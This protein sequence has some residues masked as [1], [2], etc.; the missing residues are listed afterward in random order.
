[1]ATSYVAGYVAY[2]LTLDSS[3]T[4]AIVDS[5]IKAQSLKNILSGIR[6]FTDGSTF[7]SVTRNSSFLHSGW[8]Y[9]RFAQQRSLK[10][11][12]HSGL[13]KN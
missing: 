3:L 5:V 2:L 8:N 7:I 10:I 11:V 12:L 6:K 13:L 1:M 4:P 9:Q